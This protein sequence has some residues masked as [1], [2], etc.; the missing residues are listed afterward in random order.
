MLSGGYAS[1]RETVDYE[2]SLWN[3]DY[4]ESACTS[5]LINTDS[6]VLDNVTLL[7][8]LLGFRVEWDVQAGQPP[9]TTVE[10]GQTNVLLTSALSYNPFNSTVTFDPGDLVF[11]HQAECE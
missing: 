3:L 5:T 8:G 6:V 2:G 10:I 1:S 7:N 9:C 11:V 4:N